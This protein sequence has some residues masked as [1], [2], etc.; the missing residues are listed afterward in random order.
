LTGADGDALVFPS[1]SGQ[2]RSYSNWRER[3]WNPACVAVGLGQWVDV[4]REPR[5]PASKRGKRARVA[6]RRRYLGLTFHDLRRAN[7]SALVAQGVDLKT[8][9]TRLGHADPRLTLAVYAQATSEA[10]KAAAELVGDRFRR[11]PALVA[12]EFSG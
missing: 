5:K 3:V 12:G 1:K 2:L 9:Q 10:D 4:E 8:A 7:A 6:S 11:H